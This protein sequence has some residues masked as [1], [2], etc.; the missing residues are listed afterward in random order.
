MTYNF[1][2]SKQLYF[3][4]FYRE[5]TSTLGSSISKQRQYLEKLLNQW[6]HFCSH[7]NQNEVH[8]MGDMNI[9]FLNNK[10]LTPGYHLISLSRML[11]TTCDAFNLS[12]LVLEPT[13]QQFD[14]IN[15]RTSISCIDHIYTN[16]KYRCS[17]ARV[18]PFGAS[19]HNLIGYTR[20]SKLPPQPS[21]TIRKRSYKDFDKNKF[22]SDLNKLDWTDVYTCFDIDAAVEM[23]TW[24]INTV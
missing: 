24:K 20:Y 16:S 23:L 22:I 11:K 21:T 2:N 10:W 14:R 19:D 9:D 13:R 5:Y 17:N 1:E 15:N 12:Q 7:Q 18:I 3:C 8:F 4:H 6:E